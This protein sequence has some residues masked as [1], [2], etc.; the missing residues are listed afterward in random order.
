MSMTKMEGLMFMET[1]FVLLRCALIIGRDGCQMMVGSVTLYKGFALPFWRGDCL[2]SLGDVA[3]E[4]AELL[5]RVL[6]VQF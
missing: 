6:E 4:G 2:P 1:S 3:V 5:L